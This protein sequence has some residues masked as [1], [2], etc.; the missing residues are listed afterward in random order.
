MKY[1]YEIQPDGI[2]T[3]HA[4]ANEASR[5]QWIA[6]SLSARGAL[7]GNSRD[8]KAALYRD[9]V[10]FASLGEKPNDKFPPSSMADE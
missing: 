3:V 2:K 5:V 4:F 7:S 9:A 6:A 8:V 10:I 1:A